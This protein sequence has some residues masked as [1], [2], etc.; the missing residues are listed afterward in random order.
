[1]NKLNS[2]TRKV[3]QHGNFR[4]VAYDDDALATVQALKRLTAPGQN[5][6]TE[7]SLEPLLE[8]A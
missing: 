7:T 8:W 2:N 6:V 4:A 1:M 5:T 3:V